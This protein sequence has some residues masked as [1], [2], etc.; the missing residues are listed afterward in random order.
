MILKPEFFNRPTVLVAKELLGKFLVRR[1]GKKEI[2]ATI[3]EVEVYDGF[4][5]RASHAARGMTLR[6]KPMFGPAGF[7]YVYLVYGMPGCYRGNCGVK[8]AK[9]C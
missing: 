9:S 1:V 8:S 6:N 5:D 3:T 7:W 2:S 4:D